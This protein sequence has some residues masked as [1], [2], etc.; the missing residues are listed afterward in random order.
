MRELGKKIRQESFISRKLNELAI[1]VN[2][3]RA[4]VIRKEQKVHWDKFCFFKEL[5]KAMKKIGG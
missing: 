4:E 2:Y 5:D 3:K 1:D